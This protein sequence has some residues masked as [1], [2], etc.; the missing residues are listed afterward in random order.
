[1]ARGLFSKWKTPVYVGFDVNMTKKLLDEVICA[2]HD[3]GHEVV[4]CVSDMG[5]SNQGLWK[6]LN[7]NT[8]QTF[9]H[10][11]VTNN[12]IWMFADVP[13]LLKLTRNW[14][15]DSGKLF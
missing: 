15:F 14:L 7:V 12:K 5:T 13:H 6:E 10:H 2:L 4:A 9:F 11:P 3:V 1:M 8:S